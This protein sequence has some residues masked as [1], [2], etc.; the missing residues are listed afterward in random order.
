MILQTASCLKSLQCSN[1]VVTINTE[2]LGIVSKE[3][4][5]RRRRASHVINY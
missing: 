2:I 4:V 1:I 5:F 3:S